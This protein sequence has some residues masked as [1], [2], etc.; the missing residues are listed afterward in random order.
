[1]EQNRLRGWPGHLA[2]AIGVSA[3]AMSFVLVA[4][5]CGGSEQTESFS[6][7]TMPPEF[8]GIADTWDEAPLDE[9]FEWFGTGEPPEEILYRIRTAPA[10]I[11]EMVRSCNAGRS[12]DCL[13]CPVQDDPS[14]IPSE[15]VE[16]CS[17][18][19]C[20]LEP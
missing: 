6:V 1:M 7:P 10:Y 12:Y 15:I 19:P 5:S 18:L 14:S 3:W 11:A 2:V 8:A 9:V 13:E 17:E 20:C 4:T 16:A